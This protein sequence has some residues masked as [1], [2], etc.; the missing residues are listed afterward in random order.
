MSLVAAEPAPGAVMPRRRRA[1]LADLLCGF[2]LAIWFASG[3]VFGAIVGFLLDHPLAHLLL[4]GSISAQVVGGAYAREGKMSL[5]VVFAA[6]VV[7][8]AMFDP[9][10][11]WVGRRYGDKLIRV[12]VRTRVLSRRGV[13]RGE[14]I[15]GRYGGLAV[16][17]SW[18]LPVPNTVIYAAVGSAGMSLPLFLLLDVLAALLWAGLVVG[19]GYA[20]GHPAVALAVEITHYAWWVFGVSTGLTVAYLLWRHRDNL[21]RQWSRLRRRP[22]SKPG[23]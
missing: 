19:L 14:R 23:T 17:L 8:S 4:T 15:I 18:Y 10:F 3:Y 9:L 16:L 2:G 1:G 5:V 6:A 13:D 21:A 7:G 11:Y 22:V 12:L 20:I